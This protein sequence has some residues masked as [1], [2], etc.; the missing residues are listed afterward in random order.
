[1]H[2]GLHIFAERLYKCTLYS[3]STVSFGILKLLHRRNFNALYNV[4]TM[5]ILHVHWQYKRGQKVRML[6][7]IQIFIVSGDRCHAP[8]IRYSVK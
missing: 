3:I 5:Y 2:T 6:R 4:H 1:M 8:S 7:I